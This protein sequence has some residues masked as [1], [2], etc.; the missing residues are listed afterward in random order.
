[1]ILRAFVAATVTALTMSACGGSIGSSSGGALPQQPAPEHHVR[2]SKYIKHV[3]IMIQ[4]NRSFDDLFATFPGA[5]GTTSGKVKGGK[6]IQ[7]QES[8]LLEKCDFSHGYHVFLS[9]YDNGNMDGFTWKGE[10]SAY[11]KTVNAEYQ[12]VD[13]SQITPYWDIAEQY[14]LGDHM[15]QTQG[16]GS[17]TAHQDLIRGSTTID[18]GQAQ[19]LVDYPTNLPWG[20]DASAGTVTSLLVWNGTEIQYKQNQGPFPCSNKFP[21]S[22]SSYATLRDLLDAKSIS[23]KYYSPSVKPGVGGYWN[24]F[25]TVA[26]VRYGSEWGVNVTTKYPYEKQIFNDISAGK[27]PA[28]S[29]LIPDEGNSDHPQGVLDNGPS[30][31][32]SVVNAIGTSS[33]WKSTAIIIVWDDWGGFYDHVPPPSF[34][35]WGGLGFRVPMLLVSAYARKGSGS[36]GGLVSHTQYEFG[37]ILK[38]IENNWR[39]GSLGTSD[40]RANSIIDC[41]DFTQPARPFTSIPSK[42]SRAYFMRQPPSFLPIDTE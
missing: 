1:M 26:P 28:V 8:P 30:W 13:P 29:W 10:P 33:Y 11:C 19:S 39:L 4:E 42:Y 23:W 25:D 14:V 40:A 24:A 22:G 2:S 38:F 20:C 34:D 5:D 37:S 6:T 3:I 17:Y 36:Q 12:Y 18:P 21:G 7:L 31:I 16:S 9:D 32:A 35:H 15:F 27:L 41:F